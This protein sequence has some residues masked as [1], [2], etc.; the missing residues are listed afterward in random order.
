MEGNCRRQMHQGNNFATS[1]EQE[2][3]RPCHHDAEGMKI[4]DDKLNGNNNNSSS[5]GIS[6]SADSAS[7]I[8]KQCSPCPEPRALP[9]N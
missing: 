1:H 6:R 8:K 4:V 2:R 5:R 3:S 7:I 9:L